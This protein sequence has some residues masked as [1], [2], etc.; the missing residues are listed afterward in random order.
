[1][2]AAQPGE[3]LEKPLSGHLVLQGE[4]PWQIAD[5]CPY[6]DTLSPDVQAEDRATAT[7]RPQEPEQGPYRRGLAGPVGP[8][9][10]EDLPFLHGEIHILYAPRFA[11]VGLGKLLGLYRQAHQFLL[12]YRGRGASLL[13]LSVRQGVPVYIIE[14]VSFPR[15]SINR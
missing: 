13:A 15:G 1:M 8:E 3:V 9:E 2:D 12:S 4:L 5:P 10:T 14:A 7:R 11:A 6:L